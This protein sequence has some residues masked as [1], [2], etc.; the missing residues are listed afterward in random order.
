MEDQ[1]RLFLL[2]SYENNSL[3]LII[4]GCDRKKMK[5]F[6]W[7]PLK[8]MSNNDSMGGESIDSVASKNLLQRTC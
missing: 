5:V 2:E 3:Y 6:K 1:T 7:I 8:R 4:P